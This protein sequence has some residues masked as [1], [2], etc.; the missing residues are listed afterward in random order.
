MA[1]WITPRE[2]ID[3]SEWLDWNGCRLRESYFIY[4]LIR[5]NSHG[6]WLSWLSFQSRFRN[7]KRYR[8]SNF[9]KPPTFILSLAKLDFRFQPQKERREFNAAASFRHQTCLIT[10]DGMI[11]WTRHNKIINL[12]WL[13]QLQLK[14]NG[15]KWNA[16]NLIK[17]AAAGISWAG[18]Y[19]FHS[20]SC[21]QIHSTNMLI[22]LNFYTLV[23]L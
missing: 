17:F 15:R 14:L 9:P 12:T 18:R 7:L 4:S 3:W 1:R 19:L 11:E 20:S 23:L 8:V 16:A 22:H 21:L 6:G 10:A 13:M 2:K 5:L